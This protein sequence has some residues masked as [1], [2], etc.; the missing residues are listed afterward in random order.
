VGAAAR[1]LAPYRTIA[2][3]MLTNSHLVL[4]IIAIAPV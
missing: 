2:M 1:A 3:N 4:P